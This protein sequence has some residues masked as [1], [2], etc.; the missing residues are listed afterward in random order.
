MYILT[1]CIIWP[2]LILTSKSK[3]QKNLQRYAED[4]FSKL[5]MVHFYFWYYFP[6]LFVPFVPEVGIMYAY[7]VY[8]T[9]RRRVLLLSLSLSSMLIFSQSLFFYHIALLFIM[10]K[11]RQKAIERGSHPLSLLFN[12]RTY[13]NISTQNHYFIF[14]FLGH[15]HDFFL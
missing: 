5:C 9:K 12:F 13:Q 4:F 7:C 6:M 11:T 3:L 10:R 1:S 2:Q 15:F 14:L 8:H